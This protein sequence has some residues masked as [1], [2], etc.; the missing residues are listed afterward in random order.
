MSHLFGN[1]LTY[2]NS[3]TVAAVPCSG[4]VL[5]VLL[6][7]TLICCL[8]LPAPLLCLPAACLLGNLEIPVYNYRRFIIFITYIFYRK[9]HNFISNHSSSSNTRRQQQHADN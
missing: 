5:L 6:P 7:A 4:R 2:C 1:Y 8:C 3:L 9:Y